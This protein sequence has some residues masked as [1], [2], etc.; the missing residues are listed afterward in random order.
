MKID[1]FIRK[2]T[3]HP[4]LFIGTGIS[5]RYLKNSFTWDGLLSYIS[6][7]LKGTEEF[8]Y[9]LKSKHE[10]DGT[11]NYPGIASELEDEFNNVLIKD[12]DGKFK[13]I[14][15]LFYENMRMGITISRFKLYIAYLLKD[16]TIKEEKS[17]E[18]NALKKVR[19]NIGCVIT[20]N[21]DE[22]IE[23]IFEFHPLIGN[24]ILLSNPY[25][26]VYK[27][28]GC[29][30]DPA[31]IIITEKDYGNFDEKY[32]LIR[33]QLLSLFIHNPII[34][35]GYN[36]ADNNIKSILKTI[37]TY[38]NPNTAEAEK[39]RENFLLVEYEEGSQ[40]VEVV[41][42]DIDMSG[43]ATIRI[44]K[45]KTDN[46]L[47]IYNNLANLNLPISAMD[48]RKV[49][50]VVKE[51]YSGGEISVS[52]TEDIESLKNGEKILAIGS[53]KT[54]KYEYQTS[55]EMMEN[56]FKIIDESN[57]QLL[58][59]I[60]KQKIQINQFFPIFGFGIIQPEL[61]SYERLKG[62]QLEK[63]RKLIEATE[64][65]ANEYN[66]IHEIIEDEN[67]PQSSKNNRIIKALIDDRV[68]LD[69]VEEYLRNYPN[70]KITDYRRLLSVYDY[71]KYSGL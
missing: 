43:F 24:N 3:N 13:E 63:I 29:V 41:D 52:I 55:S 18:I 42:H 34:F 9:D 49:Q 39:I 22:F 26:S 38:I 37:F 15:N 50:T 56:Y 47:E 11:F 54:I 4:V 58:K 66:T 51:I 53:V 62:I 60:D 45:I 6:K 69:D 71:K 7:E 64:G 19:K 1:E 36:I 46:F 14:N 2:F 27:I 33:A 31:K 44:N 61:T 8:Y 57:Y 10:R 23:E 30:D 35:L 25:G 59:L 32:E 5:L 12:R 20:T 21:Y 28:H 68:E 48:I 67:I 40:N 70:K 17:N 16:L 65:V